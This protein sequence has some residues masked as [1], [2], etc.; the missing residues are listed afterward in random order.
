MVG[1]VTA[2]SVAWGPGALEQLGGLGA[3]RAAVVLDPTVAALEGPRRALEELERAGASVTVI[4]DCPASTR[5]DDVAALAGRLRGAEADWV[6]AIGGGTTIDAAKA[7]RLLAERPELALGRPPVDPSLPERPKTRLAAVPTTSGSGAEASWTVDL[8]DADDRPFELAHRSL[9]PEWAI[10]DPRFVRELAPSAVVEGALQSA[11]LACE[12]YLSAWASPFSDALAVDAVR[13]VTRR[14][15]HA[16]RWSDDPDARDALHY[17]ATMAGLAASNAQRGVAHALARALAR[18]T[19]LG[20]G[21]LLGMALPTVLEFDRPSARDRLEAL[22]DALRG[23][24]DATTVPVAERLRRMAA[25]CGAPRDL[26]AAGVEP[27]RIE[28]ARARIVA[29]TL[30][31]PA[32]L[33]NPRV[34]SPADVTTLLAAIAGPGPTPDAAR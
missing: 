10:V 34:P 4:G 17:A 30:R 1:F 14:L 12:A 21:T 32:V 28:T 24:G 27:T 20:Y 19:G 33:A 6:V 16:L 7:A 2:P 25:A 8:F 31:S 13:T 23:P 29:D 9:V 22:A 18:P 15:P 26:A 5:V 3:R 11:A